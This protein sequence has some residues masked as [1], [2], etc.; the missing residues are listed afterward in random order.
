MFIIYGYDHPKAPE[1]S[2]IS[3]VFKNREDAKKYLQAIPEQFKNN[4][5]LEE[6]SQKDYPI[7]FVEDFQKKTI[8]PIDRFE[9]AKKIVMMPKIEDDDHIYFNFYRF[10]EDYCSKHPGEDSLGWTDHTHLDNDYIIWSLDASLEKGEVEYSNCYFHCNMCGRPGAG[11][12]RLNDELQTLNW[13]PPEN[14][15]V[16]TTCETRK[17][18]LLFCQ[19]KCKK[20]FLG[21]S[22][23]AVS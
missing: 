4:N 1:R 8:Y 15:I 21:T 10:I 3:G 13:V 17:H 16:D 2:Y 5:K 12:V 11:I 14:W 20:S 23:E 18:P 6:I 9:L 22:D 19:Q 7:Y